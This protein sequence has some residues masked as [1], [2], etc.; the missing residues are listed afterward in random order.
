MRDFNVRKLLI[1]VSSLLAITIG[2]GLLPSSISA[3]YADENGITSSDISIGGIGALT[4]PL[5]FI[6]TPGRDSMTM[7]FDEINARG[8]VCGRKLHL[9]FQ[10]A[11]SP[12]ES[13]A[14]VKKLV[15]EDK[16]FILVLASGSTGAAAAADYVRQ[17]GVPTYNLYGSTPI[18]RNPFAKNV[19][20]GA[21][22]PVDV[23]AAALI[24][25][26]YDGGY[27]PH[28]FGVLAGTYAFPQ[29]TLKAVQDILQRKKAN[30]TVEQFDIGARDFTSQLVSL[31]RQNVDAVLVLGSFSEAGFAIKQAREMGIT[32]VR[33]VVDGSAVS[34]AIIP[35]LGNADGIRG[36]YNAPAFPGQTPATREFEARLQKY[37][38]SLPQGRPSI[39]DLIGY[40][41][42]YVVA[43]AIKA[44]NCQLTRD[45]LINAWSNLKLAGP[46]ALDGLDVTFPESYTTTDHQG[47][48][49]IGAAI[50]KDGQWQVYRVIDKP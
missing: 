6:G 34:T 20:N 23:S 1:C 2:R 33:W 8:G 26:F 10:H 35:I 12:A 37:L 3:A 24:S 22:V 47:V 11:S 31:Q 14:A 46:K 21:V 7:A 9:D 48:Y 15:E 28:K 42:G 25:M 36:Y 32:N 30:F 19:F 39:Y 29:A 41:S 50:V 13:L 17:V 27:T 16:V 5:A 43:E 44:T 38:G 49:R 45:N 40:G 4:G 18:I